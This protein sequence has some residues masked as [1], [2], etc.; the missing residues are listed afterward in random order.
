MSLTP[1]LRSVSYLATTKTLCGRS[2]DILLLKGTKNQL[3]LF[4]KMP[5][6][7]RFLHA[8]LTFQF[9]LCTVTEGRF[10]KKNTI[11]RLHTIAA[12]KIQ[13]LLA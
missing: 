6:E 2:Q 8:C 11:K 5:K 13:V 7:H 9:R 3:S 10:E 1:V 4:V 12:Q